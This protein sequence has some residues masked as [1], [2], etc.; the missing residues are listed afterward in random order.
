MRLDDA[1]CFCK[2][3]KLYF[4]KNVTY[5]SFYVTYNFCENRCGSLTI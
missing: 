3:Y 5:K 2:N 4:S 1:F